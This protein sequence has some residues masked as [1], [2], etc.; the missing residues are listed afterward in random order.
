MKPAFE[1][2]KA[3][4]HNSFVVR[5]FSEKKFSAPYHYHPEFELTLIVKGS[6]KRYVGTHM[7]DYVAGDLVLLGSNVPHCWKSSADTNSKSVSIVVHFKSDFLGK[8]FFQLPEMQKTAQ[9][10]NESAKGVHFKKYTDSISKNIEQLLKEDDHHQKLMLLLHL[11]Q[12]LATQTK[13]MAL[14]KQSQLESLSSSDKMRVQQVLGY[15]VDNFK[16]SISLNE[17]ASIANMSP[18]AFCKYFKRVTRKTFI[19]TV[20]DYRI[21]F[22]VLELVNTDKSMAQICY[23]SG[24]NDLSNFYKTFR[25]KMKISPLQYRVSF[26]K[27][28]NT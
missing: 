17:A 11:L 20:N 19:E 6:G 16:E 13:Y 5:K 2:V 15:I 4:M 22:A 25:S 1:A 24:F 3:S 12:Q 9:L 7:Q 10:L 8:D 21:D 28:L 14:Q 26:D 27:K 18:T 23:D